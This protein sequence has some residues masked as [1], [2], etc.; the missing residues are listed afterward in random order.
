MEHRVHSRRRRVAG[1]LAA[2]AVVVL[3]VL[4]N[5]ATTVAV[6]CDRGVAFTVE[7]SGDAQTGA[8][9]APLGARI[10]A[11]VSCRAQGSGNP[12]AAYGEPVAW[13]VT[14]GGGLVDGAAAVRK[15]VD[16]G[17][18]T[19]V[20]WTL[21]PTI[22]EQAARLTV[23]GRVFDFRATAGGP[24]S[25]GTCT[26]GAGTTLEATREVE[27]AERWTLAGSPYRGERVEVRPDAT[28]TIDP[29]VTVC[30]AE[31]TVMPEARLVANGTADAPVR[32]QPAG[33]ATDWVL[34]LLPAYGSAAR[35]PSVLRHVEADRL[36][37]LRIWQHPLAIEDSRFAAAGASACGQVDWQVGS[38]PM[39][40]SGAWRSVFDG[41]GRHVGGCPGPAV[42]IEF[43]G[44]PPDLPT[45]PFEARVLNA[46]GDAVRVGGSVAPFVGF[47]NCEIAGSAQ[48][49]LVV[50]AD[51]RGA[52][53]VTVSGC[54]FSGNV[55]F[56]L[57]N[58][59][60]DGSG[61]VARGN[62]W[63]DPAGPPATG[64]NAVS[65]SV[66][67]AAPAAAPFV[68]GY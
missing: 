3:G 13:S 7:V 47:A 20:T 28:L 18:R 50:G 68:L 40:G 48:N 17:G 41:Y 1:G 32:L 37:A 10:A 19:G 39:G 24:A 16:P 8:A 67:T 31:M 63:G 62:W 51:G 54:N 36:V 15:T 2:A 35:P 34:Q 52:A 57:R 59:R 53:A 12:L 27:G 22:G 6:E 30:V 38:G 64:P 5:L 4:S 25:G 49:G 61:I 60:A 9:N 66:D 21:G 14:A 56:A 44:R 42:R 43:G 33:G 11:Q 29:G 26:G 58:E 55:G 46:G 23:A 45:L 65:P